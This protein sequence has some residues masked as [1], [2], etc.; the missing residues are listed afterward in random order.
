MGRQSD[1]AAGA[2]GDRQRRGWDRAVH[3][4]ELTERLAMLRE[5]DEPFALIRLANYRDDP[6]PLCLEPWGEAIF[7][8][9]DVE[10]TLLLVGVLDRADPIPP[11]GLDWGKDCISLT[12]YSDGAKIEIY[13]HGELL[14][15]HGTMRDGSI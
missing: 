12:S 14:W 8:L 10:Y 13:G 1:F 2:C 7:L 5:Q 4:N 15:A 6:E 11:V 9:P 3:A